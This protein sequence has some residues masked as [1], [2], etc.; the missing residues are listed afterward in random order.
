MNDLIYVYYKYDTIRYNNDLVC[1]LTKFMDSYLIRSSVYSGYRTYIYNDLDIFSTNDLLQIAFRV[2][3]AT[4]GS[5]LLKRLND[6][7]FEIIG[8]HFNRDVCFDEFACY[9]IRLEKDIQDYVGKVLDF[10]NV[11]LINNKREVESNE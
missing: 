7:Q 5:I 6:N 3:G 1:S 8:F 2:P 4:R 10:S 9:D 11:Q